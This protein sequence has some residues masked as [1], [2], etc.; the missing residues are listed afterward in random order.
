M[1]LVWWLS[2]GIRYVLTCHITRGN[3]ISGTKNSLCQYYNTCH[4][5]MMIGQ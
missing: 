5:G 3:G 4:G 2:A 1:Y